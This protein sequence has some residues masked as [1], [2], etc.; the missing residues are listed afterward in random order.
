MNIVTAN[1][2]TNLIL[3]LEAF[4]P[5]CLF[6]FAGQNNPEPETPFCLITLISETPVGRPQKSHRTKI[7]DE[8]TE[9]SY[10][11]V[12]QDYEVNFTLTFRGLNFSVAEQYARYL[13]IGLESDVLAYHMSQNGFGILSYNSFPRAI[14]NI[15]NTVNYVNDT[16]DITLLTNRS[17][18]FA[19]EHFNS[20]NIIGTLKGSADGTTSIEVNV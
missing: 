4:I 20:T 10:Q 3:A 2:Q 15:N 11:L 16:V 19:I 6:I 9:L 13:S 5:D 12:Q 8:L 7:V 18:E 17:E 1:Y 14:I